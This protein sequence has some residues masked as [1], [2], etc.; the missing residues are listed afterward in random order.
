MGIKGDNEE[1]VGRFLSVPARLWL[2]FMFSISAFRPVRGLRECVTVCALTTCVVHYSLNH[3][4]G[5]SH[6]TFYTDM[7]VL[8]YL[9]RPEFT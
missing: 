3:S 1:V 5:M 9:R 7:F 8:K 6:K 4:Q 2:Y